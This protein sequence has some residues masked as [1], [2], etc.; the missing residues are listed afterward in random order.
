MGKK[1]LVLWGTALL[2]HAGIGDVKE[3]KAQAH[4]AYL[5]GRYSESESRYRAVL[6]D[7]GR[8]ASLSCAVVR[9]NLG[10]ALRAQGR[11]AEARPY[12]E[13]AAAQIAELAGVD[14]PEAVTARTNLAGLY[15]ST[16]ELAKAAELSS[17]LIQSAGEVTAVTLYGNLSAAAIGMGRMEE[18]AGYARKG[19]ELA[20]R[21][22]PGNDPRHAAVLNNL[23]Q[24]CRFTGR[25]QEAEALYREALRMWEASLGDSHPDLARGLMNLA[26][27][28][29]ERGREAGAEQLYLR[30]AAILEKAEPTLALVARNELADV[31]RAE[32]RYTEARKL[33]H[34]TLAKIEATMPVTDARVVRAQQNWQRLIAET[35]R[36]AMQK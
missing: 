7:C 5:A 36:I 16:G 27:F 2:A 20:K 10:V 28:Y 14:S 25:F 8:E 17:T 33:A 22:L 3:R 11:V 31:L 18:A 30:S 15:W 9:E 13:E 4:A 21:V 29:H 6:A 12:M 19:V 32:L 23:A 1:L 26:A 24:A 35:N 34:T